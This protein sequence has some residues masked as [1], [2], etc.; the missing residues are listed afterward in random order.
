MGGEGFDYA[1]YGTS[2]AAVTVNL[3]TESAY[4]GH[5]SGD[6]LNE[7]E[8]VLG[9]AFEDDLTGAAGELSYLDG[10]GGDDTLTT[11]GMS[12]WFAGGEGNDTFVFDSGFQGVRILDF[13]AGAGSED[14]MDLRGLGYRS[15]DQIMADAYQDGGSTVIDTGTGHSIYLSNVDLTSLHTDDFLLV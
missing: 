5:A 8:G 2:D 3:T 7:I 11:G 4:G 10:G 6:V 14:V 12:G 1:S 15:F 9:S 13:E